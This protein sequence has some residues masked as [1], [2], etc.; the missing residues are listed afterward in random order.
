[1]S[2]AIAKIILTN[3]KHPFLL[4]QRQTFG[5]GVAGVSHNLCGLLT[6]LFQNKHGECTLGTFPPLPLYASDVQDLPTQA[7]MSADTAKG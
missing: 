4:F 2:H 5:G 7:S 1:M 3:N 6:G